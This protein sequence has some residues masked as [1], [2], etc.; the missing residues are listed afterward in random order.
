MLLID[1]VSEHIHLALRYLIVNTVHSLKSLLS[2]DIKEFQDNASDNEKNQKIK[3][4][5]TFLFYLYDTLSILLINLLSSHVDN[6]RD[7]NVIDNT[8]NLLVFLMNYLLD[9]FSFNKRVRY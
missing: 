6:Y 2:T 9:I 1:C 5:S 3:E 7:N 4:Y 8:V